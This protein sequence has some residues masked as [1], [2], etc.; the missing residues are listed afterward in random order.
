MKS[1]L[2]VLYILIASLLCILRHSFAQISSDGL[3]AHYSFSGDF[4]DAKSSIL[5]VNHGASFT[6]DRFGNP[7]S[8]LLIN[9]TSSS[10][11]ATGQYV[12]LPNP[13]NSFFNA[14]FT[15]VFWFKTV[16]KGRRMYLLSNDQT[17]DC[18]NLNFEL[19]DGTASYLYWNGTGSPGIY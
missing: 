17:S 4:K 19:N 11:Q 7:N 13:S 2:R 12:S 9:N 15:I 14:D 3:V 6:T 10:I 1:K 18:S 8:A 16:D 5:G